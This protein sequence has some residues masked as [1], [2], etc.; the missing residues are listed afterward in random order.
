MNDQYVFMYSLIELIIL[1]Q[2]EAKEQQ[3]L[4]Q[5]EESEPVPVVDHSASLWVEKY[6]PNCYLDLLSEEP[7]NRAL[8]HWLHLWDM[9]VYT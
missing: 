2:L 8:L 9:V 3:K 6:R 4:K 7:V 5:E 1:F